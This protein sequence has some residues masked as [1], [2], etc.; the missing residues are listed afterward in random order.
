MFE[1][2]TESFTSYTADIHLLK[3]MRKVRD[4][5][6]DLALAEVGLWGRFPAAKLF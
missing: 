3:I 4:K 6:R 1:S 2:N 5:I